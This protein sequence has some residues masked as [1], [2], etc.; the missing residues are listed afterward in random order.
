[1]TMEA[2]LRMSCYP[3][4]SPSAHENVMK[5]F[6]SEYPNKEIHKRCWMGTIRVKDKKKKMRRKKD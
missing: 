6:L 3:Q 1:M 2:V 5:L 4:L